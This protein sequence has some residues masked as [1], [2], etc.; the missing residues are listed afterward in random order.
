MTNRLAEPLTIVN[1]RASCGC[2]SGRPSASLVP[3]GG[4]AVIEAEMDTRNFVG[5]KATVLTVTLLTAGGREAEARLGVSSNILSDI[6]LNPGTVDFGSVARGQ[7]PASVLTIDRIGAAGWKVERMVTA[8]RALDASLVETTRNASTVSYALTVALKPAAPAGSLREEIRLLTNDAETPSIPV[9][10]TAQIRG[11]LVASPSVLSLG[12]V[13]AAG[14]AQGRFLVRGA[15]PFA[16]RS[17]EGSGDGF[18]ANADDTSAKPL[19][20]VAVSYKPE[21]GTT[22]GDVRRVFRV[23][24]DLPGEPP[25]ELTATLH[26]DP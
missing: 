6:V 24:T 23:V 7:S 16:I 9:L 14:G 12:Q 26:V 18:R 15:K 17:V 19:H 4:S 2:T 3:P 5:K 22:R 8:S 20:V 21:E 1:V 25:L 10:V 13:T 11:D